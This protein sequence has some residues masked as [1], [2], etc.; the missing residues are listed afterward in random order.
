MISAILLLLSLT[1]LKAQ[2]SS[3]DFYLYNNNSVR[4]IDN[5]FLYKLSPAKK[6]SLQVKGISSNETR[7]NFNQ[8][9][10]RANLEMALGVEQGILSHSMLSGFDY[11]FDKNDLETELAAFRSRTAY[12]GYGL[13]I[14]PMDSLNFN[15]QI[16]GYLKRE[17]D[18]YVNT[19]E[20]N[21]DGYQFQ[22]RASY[23]Y[24]SN[25][26]YL[27]LSGN[28]DI[29]QLDWE[30]YQI[31]GVNAY[32]DQSLG[33]AYL[34]SLFSLNSRNDKLYT[35]Q[36]N[37]GQLSSY[38]ITDRQKRWN[39]ISDNR[40]EID[41]GDY[42]GFKISNTYSQRKTSLDQNINRNNADFQNQASLI[43]EF[44]PTQNL[45]Q[46]ITLNHS[47]AIKDFSFSNASR[48]SDLRL[49]GSNLIW[50]YLP[51]DSLSVGASIDLQR[52]SYPYDDHRLDNDLRQFGMKMSWKHYYKDR[53]RLGTHFLWSIKDDVY[54]DSLLSGNNTRIKS[55]SLL[56]ECSILLG[57]RLALR[58]NYQVRVDFTD[59]LYNTEANGLYRQ[60][61]ARYNLVF[62]SYPFVARSLDLRWLELPFRTPNDS[63]F[64]LDALISYERSEYGYQEEDYYLINSLTERFTAGLT[65]RHDIHSFY[66]MLQPR[67]SWGTWNEYSLL[68]AA[69]YKFN[70]SSVLE[71]NLNPIGDSLNSLDWRLSINLALAY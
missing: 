68:L 69:A 26:G 29:K 49:L 66:W 8:N 38:V 42:L 55:L 15:A 57:D 7:L 67:I 37:T 62:D 30:D 51:G 58:Q 44:R 41:A 46:F 52:T 19:A 12:M 59:F 47:Y 61:G 50:E 70:S 9:T 63:A 20:L 64:L 11:H 48:H 27:G 54:I 32:L 43:T 2:N 60:F 16:N 22:S 45:R 28:L 53:I 31:Y 24:V 3:L 10:R 1:A 5:F 35:L 6:T 33:A 34:N 21:G 4:I 13:N 14:S 18:R 23:G 56:P 65:L 25:T 36:E 39:L 40:L 71:I 17:Q